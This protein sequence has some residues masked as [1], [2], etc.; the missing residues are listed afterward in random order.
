MIIHPCRSLRIPLTL[1]EDVT[2][3]PG[4]LQRYNLAVIFPNQ[5]PVKFNMA[6]PVASHITAQSVRPIPGLQWL[7]LEQLGNHVPQ[8]LRIFA[9]PTHPSEVASV[10]G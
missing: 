2:V 8:Q 10:P 7:P 6:F 4:A 3:C 5:K 1:P 9:S